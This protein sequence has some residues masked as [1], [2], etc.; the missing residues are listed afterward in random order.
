MYVLC[1]SDFCLQNYIEY[2]IINYI[3]KIILMMH[4]NMWGLG[5]INCMLTLLLPHRDGEVVSTRPSTQIT[6]PQK[7]K[8]IRYKLTIRVKSN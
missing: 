3:K 8:N 7:Q 6:Q 1:Y 2:V 4:V 5:R